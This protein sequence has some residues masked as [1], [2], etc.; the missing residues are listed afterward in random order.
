MLPGGHDNFTENIRFERDDIT[1]T[2]RYS[3]VRKLLLCASAFKT[4]RGGGER[5]GWSYFHVCADKRP[6]ATGTGLPHLSS[7]RGALCEGIG[8]EPRGGPPGCRLPASGGPLRRNA[9]PT[10][11]PPPPARPRRASCRRLGGQ[12]RARAGPRLPGAVRGCR[13]NPQVKLLPFQ[14]QLLPCPSLRAGV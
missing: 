8:A 12:R 3:F 9:G 2:A 10:A 5:G 1:I 4:A 14:S 7:P 6:A 11:R 13:A